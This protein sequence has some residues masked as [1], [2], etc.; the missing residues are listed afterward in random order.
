MA[1]KALQQCIR[2]TCCVTLTYEQNPAGYKVSI[3]IGPG[4]LTQKDQIG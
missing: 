1:E 3:W 4:R 2:D